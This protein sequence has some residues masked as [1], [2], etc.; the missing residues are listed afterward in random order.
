ME[1]KQLHAVIIVLNYWLPSNVRKEE[2][3]FVQK[4]LQTFLSLVFNLIIGSILL[5]LLMLIR[6]LQGTLPW[7][8]LSAC[9]GWNI[10][11]HFIEHCYLIVYV[12]VLLLNIKAIHFSI[13][14]FGF[15]I[16]DCILYFSHH[17]DAMYEHLK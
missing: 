8:N 3:T 7:V 10:S 5:V 2:S 4:V 16:F 14:I 1:T 6:L 13:C 11:L 15:N 9:E 17:F 12:S